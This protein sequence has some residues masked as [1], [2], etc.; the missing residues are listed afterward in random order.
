MSLPRIASREEWL[1]ARRELLA[2]EKEL[3]RARDALAAERRRLPMVEFAPGY[4]FDG[5]GGRVP[6]GD[7]FEGRSQLILYHFMLDQSAQPCT[8]CAMFADQVGHLAHL[9]ARDT[10][11]ALTSRA[12]QDEIKPFRRRMGWQI[13]WYTT[14]DEDFTPPAGSPRPSA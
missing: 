2:K 3:T 12:P 6:L 14:L 1:E 13:P 9:H 8:G 10:S 11:F 5:P 4:A 7:L